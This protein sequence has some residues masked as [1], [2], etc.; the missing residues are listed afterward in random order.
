MEPLKPLNL[1]RTSNSTFQTIHPALGSENDFIDLVQTVK[2]RGLEAVFSLDYS[3]QSQSVN[4]I[5][6]KVMI[7]SSFFR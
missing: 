6:F 2:K 7:Y 1:L 5:Y 3:M 4:D